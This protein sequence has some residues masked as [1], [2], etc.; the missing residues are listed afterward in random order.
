MFCKQCGKDIVG[1]ES[2]LYCGWRPDVHLLSEENA[3]DSVS[4]STK[5]VMG[6]YTDP[7]GTETQ[8]AGGM[9]DATREPSEHRRLTTADVWLAHKDSIPEKGKKII[10]IAVIVILLGLLGLC[11]ILAVFAENA[12]FM[13]KAEEI[14]LN[15][16][17]DVDDF[18]SVETALITVWSFIE[19]FIPLMVFAYILGQ[20]RAVCDISSVLILGQRI[21]ESGLNGL[22]LLAQHQGTE[23]VQIRESS[24]ISRALCSKDDLSY[25]KM[26]ITQAIANA[27]LFGAEIIFIFI[28]A[29]GAWFRFATSINELSL[30][31]AWEATGAILFDS[32]IVGFLIASMLCLIPRLIISGKVNARYKAWLG[33]ISQTTIRY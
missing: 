19:L 22:E 4:S 28:Y 17:I 13:T 5:A 6:A 29:K 12:E 25:S 8:A 7:F 3:V 10:K 31:D 26:L 11:L 18:S 32:S 14:L 15:L 24:L 33:S 1:S 30:L 2:C 21:K 27:V 23:A 20:V 9:L 16:G